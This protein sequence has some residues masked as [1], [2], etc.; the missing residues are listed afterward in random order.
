M[1]QATPLVADEL[2]EG[3]QGIR[4][5][6]ESCAIELIGCSSRAG[7]HAWDADARGTAGPSSVPCCERLLPRSRAY[8]SRLGQEFLGRDWV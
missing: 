3:V 6:G 4:R 8:Q 1:C 2:V 5:E 7:H